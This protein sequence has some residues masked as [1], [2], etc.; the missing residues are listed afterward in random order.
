[1]YKNTSETVGSVT[2]FCSGK[3]LDIELAAI[4]S[5]TLSTAVNSETL[6]PA[7]SILSSSIASLSS[8]WQS[9]ASITAFPSV[10]MGVNVTSFGVLGNIDEKLVEF[11]LEEFCLKKRWKELASGLLIVSIDIPINKNKKWSS[12]YTLQIF[13]MWK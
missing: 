6:K 3:R 4:P 7:N 8:W 5:S 2:I 10:L 1:M 12:C 13:L 11:W 9:D